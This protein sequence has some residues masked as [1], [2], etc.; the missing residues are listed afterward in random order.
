MTKEFDESNWM[1]RAVRSPQV[2]QKSR[3]EMFEKKGNNI[4]AHFFDG[5]EQEYDSVILATGYHTYFPF[6]DPSLFGHEEIKSN[7]TKLRNLY[8][9]TFY[10]RDPTL[11]VI[12]L[13]LPGVLFH[14]MESQAI[15][16]AGVFSHIEFDGAS[17][18]SPLPDI[19][20]QE[21]WEKDRVSSTGISGFESYEPSSVQEKLGKYL[22]ALGPKDRQDPLDIDSAAATEYKEAITH[23]ETLFKNEM[24]MIEE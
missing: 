10:N 1:S 7:K 22:I 2:Q 9:H 20:V 6:L 5:T 11:A 12:G 19:F 8:L 24:G 17:I 16:C 21:Q 4:V 23:L 13:P 18:R 14:T 3:I 15:A